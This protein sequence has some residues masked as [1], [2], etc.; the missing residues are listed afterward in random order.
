MNYTPEEDTYLGT[1]KSRWDQ[2][3]RHALG[4]SELVYVI[5][6][7]YLAVLE[8]HGWG[9]RLA[10][11]W[12]IAPLLGKFAQVHYTNGMSAVL[13]ILAQL[14]IHL[15]MWRSWCYVSALK[16]DHGACRLAMLSATQTG[17]TQ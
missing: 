14:V 8:L 17:I 12:R 5:S 13:N 4:V 6:A 10:F 2:A 3:R 9:R 1:L 15:Y 16:T 7:G 11:L